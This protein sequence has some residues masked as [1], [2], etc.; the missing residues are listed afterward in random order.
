MSGF[1]GGFALERRSGIASTA[2]VV[3]AVLATMAALHLMK[4]ILMPVLF[5]L[6][7]ACLLSPFTK[8]LRRVLPLGATGS[9]VVLFLVLLLLG[10]YAASLTAESL[11]RAA[12]TLPSETERLAG[13]LSRRVRDAVLAY[14][15]LR[16][17]LPD[18]G[19]IDSLGDRNRLLLM[20][21]L[22][23][24][25]GDLTGWVGQG[26]IVLILV[27]FLLAESDMLTGKV[28]RFFAST[29]KDVRAAERAYTAVIRSIRSYLITR[30]VINLALGLVVAGALRV[31]GV[32]YAPALGAIAAL[33]NY[34]PYVGPIA[35]GTLPVL[36]S[37][38]HS[39]S[40]GDALI[41]A[42]VYTA[43]IGLEGY[44]VTPY[45]LGRSLDLNG[46]TVLLACLFWGFLWGLAGL[47]L[48][49]PITVS[50][51][52]VF[53]QVPELNRWAELMSR[54][55]RTPEEPVAEPS[56]EAIAAPASA[57]RP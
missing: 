48:A 53:Q 41:V 52:L 32:R 9:A 4:P 14:P 33:A 7:L 10:L 50:L 26:F 38:A 13:I 15:Y 3:L 46:T 56:P 30:T 23:S 55:W 54:D 6:L 18:P 28:I 1:R 12:D 16:G 40:L 35:G 27:L 51:K 57:G 36:V 19:T 24:R 8:V 17:I 44:V 20:A 39:G 11:V 2:L 5:A 34:V 42:A 49:M 37:L 22:R 43:I 21:G 31:L 29:P 45:V 25:V 47:V